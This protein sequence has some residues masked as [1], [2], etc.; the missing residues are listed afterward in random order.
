LYL[1]TRKLTAKGLLKLVPCKEGAKRKSLQ[2]GKA[3]SS[4][5]N[6]LSAPSTDKSLTQRQ[7]AEEHCSAS[8]SRQK[9]KKMGPR[10]NE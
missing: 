8:Q 10:G 5:S 4:F 6:I 2:P 1:P 7:G 3:A 9:R